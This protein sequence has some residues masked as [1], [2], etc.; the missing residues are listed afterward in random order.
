[1][2]PTVTDLVPIGRFAAA[3]RLSL[4]ALR[5]Y[6]KLGLLRPAYVD[7]DS[8]YRYYR[9]D[10]LRTARL[11]GL[12][13]R[14]DMPLDTIKRTIDAADGAAA[15]AVIEGYWNDI[16]RRVTQGRRAM[17]YLRTLLRG[18]DEM[19]HEVNT[20]ETPARQAVSI[21]REVYVKDL[22]AFITEAFARLFK[23]AAAAH[24]P[25]AGHG[26]VIYHGEVNDDSNGPVE[27]CLPV[28]RGSVAPRDE[29]RLI[30][31]PAGTEAYTTITLA[32][33]KFPEILTAYDA[34]HSWIQ[35][36]NRKT[37]ASPREIYFAEESQV[38]PNDPFCEVAWPYQ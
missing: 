22:P 23:H 18:G 4:K 29:I 32:E 5:I 15:Y 3:S 38:G 13:R 7:A 33:C 14:L 27:V 11:V 6:D 16:E 8:G 10:Q 24:G 31:L 37:S 34:V 26:M 35:R 21:M 1:M 30:D 17:A 9:N 20:R 19:T 36:N 2:K 12:L 28:E 25:V